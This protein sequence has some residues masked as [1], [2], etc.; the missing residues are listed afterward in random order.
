[1]SLA[2]LTLAILGVLGPCATDT[3]RAP[4]WIAC[5]MCDSRTWVTVESEEQTVDYSPK[6]I[7][8][9][10]LEHW[11]SISSHTWHVKCCACL[12]EW[13]VTQHESPCFCGWAWNH[14]IPLPECR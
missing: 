13:S 8:C 9:Y 10:G 1:M 11:H 7:D 12:Y 3:T 2:A 6:A 14:R 5:P 4:D